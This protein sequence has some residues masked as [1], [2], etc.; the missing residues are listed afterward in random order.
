MWNLLPLGIAAVTATD[1]LELD[2]PLKIRENDPLDF[3]FLL[4]KFWPLS[5]LLKSVAIVTYIPSLLQ[6]CGTSSCER[7]NSSTGSFGTCRPL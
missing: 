7:D 4:C 5:D 1:F 3:F 6:D 2:L